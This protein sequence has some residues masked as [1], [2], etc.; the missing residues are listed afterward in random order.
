MILEALEN[1]RKARAR[2]I[3]GILVQKGYKKIGK[4]KVKDLEAAP[5]KID[6]EAVI[7]FYQTVLKKE[8]E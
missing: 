4:D 2:E 6:Y 5:E 7:E 8:R 3:V 1:Q